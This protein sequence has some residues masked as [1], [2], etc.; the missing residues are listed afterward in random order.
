MSC[1][2]DLKMKLVNYLSLSLVQF[3]Y[4]LLQ[5]IL[6]SKED[7]KYNMSWATSSLN[8]ADGPLVGQ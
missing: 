3:N 8:L 4:I 7:Y 5:Q 6:L 2:S 1:K